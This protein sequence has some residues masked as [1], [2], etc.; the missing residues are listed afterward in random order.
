[1]PWIACHVLF[2]VLAMLTPAFRTP[3]YRFLKA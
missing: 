1:M 3:L 2:L